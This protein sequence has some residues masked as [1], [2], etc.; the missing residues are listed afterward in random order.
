MGIYEGQDW[1]NAQEIAVTSERCGWVWVGVDIGNVTLRPYQAEHVEKFLHVKACLI[2]Y[3]QRGGKS[4]AS[5]GIVHRIMERGET[6]PVL[7]I[8]DKTS[9]WM[10]DHCKIGYDPATL[11][12]IFGGEKP[13]YSKGKAVMSTA[14]RRARDRFRSLLSDPQPGHIY[15]IHRAAIVHEFGLLANVPWLA[16]IGDELHGFKNR[17][18]QRTK[19]LKKIP[20]SYKI[21]LTADPD[22]CNPQDI[23]SL[24]NWLYPRTYSSFW[25]WVKKYVEVSEE[26]GQHGK[27]FS[28]GAPINVEEFRAEIAP[29]FVR[30][31]L[32]EIDPGQLPHVYEERIVGMTH[33]QRVAYDQMAAWQMMQLGDAVV[34]AEWSVV[35]YMRMQ[36]LAQASGRAETRQVWRWMNEDDPDT[37]GKR[38]VRKLCDTTKIWQTEPSPKLDALMVE[39]EQPRPCIVFSQFA[40]MIE[41]ACSRMDAVGIKYV[42]AHSDA[43]AIEA[44]KR[45][46]A[47]E[48][49]I[50]IGTTG[51]IAESLEL[52]RA[53]VIH[54]LDQPWNPR[55]RG[56]AI[57]RGQAVGKRTPLTIIDY[58]TKDTVD[59]ARLKRVRTRQQ[60]KDMLLGR[61]GP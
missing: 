27:Y 33:E 14:Q 22:D 5:L 53:E 7:I 26:Y 59:F 30:M 3:R 39:L 15:Q 28:F 23:W 40:G 11:H 25:R 18:A 45:F 58:R 47:G 50:L 54:F 35:A 24:L 38:K 8:S 12:L 31:D 57:G 21:G 19:A 44:E 42:R 55:V 49:D 56:Q 36:Q 60:W 46:Q 61:S 10:R 48:A 43:Q 34:M 20:T 17:N 32:E 1:T 37:G 2:A 51:V 16:I 13:S 6:G 9:P 41:L 29:F 4:I 52:D